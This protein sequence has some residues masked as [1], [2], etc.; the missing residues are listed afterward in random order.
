MPVQHGL[1][2]YSF[3][4]S[5]QIR[6][7]DLSNMFFQ[8]IV[9]VIL[10]SLHFHMNFRISLSVSGG[11][12]KLGSWQGLLWIYRSI[13]GVYHLNYI[14]YFNKWTWDIFLFVLEFFQFFQQY[15]LSP[16]CKFYHP[17]INLFWNILLFL[18]ST[19]SLCPYCLFLVYR[20]TIDFH[21]L[22]L[23]PANFLSSFIKSIGIFF[24]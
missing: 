1:D 9:C 24:P 11:K 13:W 12:S 3:V 10:D 23:Y 4:A 14:K 22:I 15:F 20:N 21:I 5:F 6:K 18:M 2:Y 7:C 17:L 19:T 8:K 16:V